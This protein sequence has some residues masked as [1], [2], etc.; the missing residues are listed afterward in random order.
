MRNDKSEV[1]RDCLI[2]LCEVGQT[3]K[4]AVEAI[5]PIGLQEVSMVE[6][7]E[8]IKTNIAIIYCYLYANTDL[9][10]RSLIIVLMKEKSNNNTYWTAL[11]AINPIYC[12]HQIRKSKNGTKCTGYYVLMEITKKNV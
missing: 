6:M 3:V 2:L 1:N 5:F 10:L 8:I 11:C 12:L 7:E 4:D 9:L